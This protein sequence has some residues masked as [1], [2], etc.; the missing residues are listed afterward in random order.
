M[1]AKIA[2]RANFRDCL[3]LRYRRKQMLHHADAGP[4]RSGA[5]NIVLHCAPR[6]VVARPDITFR[7]RASSH[8]SS[9]PPRSPAPR[10]RGN[11]PSRRPCCGGQSW[12]LVLAK[13]SL[14]EALTSQA[15]P[16]VIGL[17]WL[18]WPVY[19]SRSWRRDL[20]ER[21]CWR[22]R[23]SRIGHRRRLRVTPLPMS[24]PRGPPNAGCTCPCT[25]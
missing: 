5:I 13:A 7:E 25:S 23:R 22:R 17:Q 6:R 18:G 3:G 19:R 2:G 24:R 16:T 20:Q 21:R 15:P 1:P 11:S 14:Y 4:P 9:V 12:R 10:R 8:P